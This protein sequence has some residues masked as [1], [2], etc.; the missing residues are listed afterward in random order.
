M[1]SILKTMSVALSL[2][3]A[4]PVAAD[5]FCAALEDADQ[6]P[7]KYQ[8]KGPFYTDATSGWIVGRD[9][10]KS[11]F[12]VAEETSALWRDISKAFAD[13]GAQLVV[14]A[15]P[16]R[17]L[18]APEH[19]ALPVTYDRMKQQQAFSDYIAALNAAGIAAP[20]LSGFH[21]VVDEYYFARDTHWTPMG[22]FHSVVHLKRAMG[23]QTNR[24]A[25]DDIEAEGTYTEKGSLS[26]VVEATCGARPVA[27][28]VPAAT[29]VQQ[30]GAAALLGDDISQDKIALVGTSFSDRYQ[31]DA[32]QVADALSFVMDRPVDNYAVTGGGL[33]GALEAFLNTESLA[34]AEYKTVVW[35]VPYT[36]PL[37]QVDG[38]RQVLGK[39]HRPVGAAMETRT[40]TLGDA[41]TTVD[42]DFSLS[43]VSVIE[44]E[45][46]GVDTG[47]L[48]IELID[49]DGTKI[50]TR[51]TKSDRIDSA[52]RSTNWVMATDHMPIKDI[53]RIK[54]RL[55]GVNSQSTATIKFFHDQTS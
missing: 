34:T 28:T 53:A 17:P 15:A 2:A 26:A 21:S 55:T 41:W 16:P 32:Y 5:P 36:T 6:L 24:G 1:T 31:R 4:L 19:M 49:R 12:A 23:E 39:L 51:L 25:G 13:R 20:D 9:Q 46:P 7:K 38:L 54:V 30:G 27:E 35:E 10:L 22:A 33:T 43:E 52:S 14:L 45:T 8:K 44:L 37:T 18:F 48:V 42:H 29:Y 3:V 50:R 40:L 47:K 11:D